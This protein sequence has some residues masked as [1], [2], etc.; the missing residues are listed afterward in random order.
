M[1]PLSATIVVAENAETAATELAERFTRAAICSVATR[2]VFFT[3]ISGGQSPRRTFELLEGPPFADLVPWRQT[4]VFFCDE[5]CVP[6]EHEDS[7]FRFAHSVLLSKVP[8]PASNIHRFRAE[9]SP[10]EAASEYEQEL[11][12]VMGSSPRFDLVVLGMGEDRHTA[13]LFP[14]SPAIQ[15]TERWSIAVYVDKLG[16]FRLTLTPPILNNASQVAI[17]ALGQEKASAVYDVL[18]GEVD[19]QVHPVQIVYPTEGRLAWIFD[20]ESAS[21]V[22]V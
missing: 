4:H 3:A 15:E 21:K 16:A 2:G 20:Q 17:L 1:K 22:L 8:I 13:S 18:Y 9:K 12:A 5:R 7:N 11:R 6:P 19:P 10:E 14:G